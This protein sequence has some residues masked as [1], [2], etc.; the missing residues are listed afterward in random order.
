MYHPRDPQ[1]HHASLPG[2]PVLYHRILVDPAEP[3]A[4]FR[5][6]LQ[7]FLVHVLQDLQD[8]FYRQEIEI[9][10]RHVVRREHESLQ[11][12]TDLT[13]E[14]HRQPPQILKESLVPDLRVHYVDC[15]IEEVREADFDVLQCARR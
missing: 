5:E 7:V 10:V 15:G 11:P 12:V 4:R 13:F 14:L 6:I 3:P 1:P 8:D 9:V 2:E